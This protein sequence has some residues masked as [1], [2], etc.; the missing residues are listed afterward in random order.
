[1]SLLLMLACSPGEDFWLRTEDA[2]LRVRVEGDLQADTTL[3][4][5]HGGPGGGSHDYNSGLYAE[6]LEAELAV[7]YYDQRGQG[8]STGT[9]AAE[10]VT[11]QQLADDT[12]AL[13][14][15]LRHRYGEDEKLVLFGHSWGGQLGT[16]TLLDTE[17]EVQGWIEADGAHDVPLLNQYALEMFE[18][19]GTREIDAGRNQR[20][21]K[22]IR[23]FAREVD[24]EAVTLE[25]SGDI[26]YY[27]GIAEE[28]MPEVVYAEAVYGG[29]APNPSPGIPGW[30]SDLRTSD[31][32]LEE[33]DFKSTTERLHEI[34]EP[35]LLLW[36]RYDFICPPGLGEDADRLIPDSELVIYESSGHSPMDSEPEAFAQDIL[37]FVET[38]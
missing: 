7:A 22:E 4:L 10:D 16:V 8:A 25:D 11:V 15:L 27:A 20:D 1:M 17:A 36:G 13:V 3:I 19:Y 28:L 37:D 18:D 12:A 24:P 34:D 2:D 35:T 23:S 5:L 14:E 21:W 29:R 6:L 32:L 30:V 31:L 26:N 9:Y 38:L 33:V